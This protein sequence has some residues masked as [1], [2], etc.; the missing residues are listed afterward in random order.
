M[1]SS[2][3]EASDGA[4][5][6]PAAPAPAPAPAHPLPA[7]LQATLAPRADSAAPPRDP[8]TLACAQRPA[9]SLGAAEPGARG[10]RA[11][12]PRAE[13]WTAGSGGSEGRSSLRARAG[14]EAGSYTCPPAPGGGGVWARGG[15]PGG[16]RGRGAAA[17]ATIATGRGAAE[18][19]TAGRSNGSNGGRSGAYEP[20]SGRSGTQ[21]EGGRSADGSPSA[22]AGGGVACGGGGRGLRAQAACRVSR[23]GPERRARGGLRRAAGFRAGSG[24]DR[25]ADRR[26]R[27]APVRGGRGDVPRRRLAGDDAPRRRLAPEEARARA[28]ARARASR[29]LGAAAAGGERGAEEGVGVGEHKWLK[30]L[31]WGGPDKVVFLFGNR[32]RGSGAASAG[33]R[34]GRPAGS[35]PPSPPVLTGHVSSLLPY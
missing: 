11:P 22:A 19:R 29:A 1:T 7:A 4:A 35:P 20:A 6:L 32:L 17:A 26:E 13:S 5:A 23:G 16:V 14:P 27:V 12:A 15:S 30:G 10:G 24:R 8:A 21:S 33:G 34:R 2:H 28:G 18:A 25:H 9:S 3:E 31:L